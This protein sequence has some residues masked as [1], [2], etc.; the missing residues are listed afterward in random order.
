MTI[1]I[2]A[3]L[4]PALAPWM[5]NAFGVE[6]FSV[7]Y[8]GLKEA[9][10]ETIYKAARAAGAVVMTKD[11]DFPELQMRMGAPPQIILVSLGNTSNQRMRVALEQQFSTIQ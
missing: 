6:A 9:D 10:D 3:Q 8:L 11:A 5:T 1:W 7:S 2:D 4:P